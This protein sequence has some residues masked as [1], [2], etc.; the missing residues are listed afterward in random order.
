MTGPR[1]IGLQVVLLVATA[2]IFAQQAPPP[3]PALR[4]ASQLINPPQSLV[5]VQQTIDLSEQLGSEE[6]LMTLDGE[7]LPPMLTKNVTLGLVVDDQGHVVTRLVGIGPKTPPYELLVTPQ[8]GRPVAGTFIGFDPVTGLCVLKVDL[9]KDDSG[10]FKPVTI[11][12][13]SATPANESVKL[14]GFN[15]VQ[16]ISPRIGFSRPRIHMFD[17]RILPATTDFRYQRSRPLYCLLN[18]KL[19]AIQDGTLVVQENGSIFGVASH[20]TTEQGRSIV[21]PLGR[22]KSVADE[23]IRSKGSLAHGWLGATGITLYAPI[24]TPLKSRSSDVGV[25][26]T[27][28]FP[29]SPAAEAGMQVKDILVAINDRTVTT[30]EQLSSALKLLAVDSDVTI[31]VKRGNEFRQLRA[32][33]VSAPAAESGQRL[34]ALAGQLRDLEDKLVAL[35]PADPA[36]RDLEPK[37][38][39]MRTIMD[40]VLAPAPPEVRLRV[41]YGLEVAPLTVQ[42]MRY[43]AVPRGVLIT[44]VIDESRATR[45]GLKAGDCITAIGERTVVDAQSVLQALDQATQLPVIAVSRHREEMQLTLAQ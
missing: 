14:Y 7:P 18:P 38:A 3:S 40:S 25:R 41:R 42:L 31:K 12:S 8:R 21:Y 28:V 45:S 26:I 27:G 6:N 16:T 11:A 36:R 43:F 22:I 10:A 29:D 1:I 9:T 23:V 39:T 15:A 20:D 5:Y 2:V 13:E 44:S 33:L 32:K 24:A 19:T 37:V 35:G 30:V 4:Q 17:G 34:A